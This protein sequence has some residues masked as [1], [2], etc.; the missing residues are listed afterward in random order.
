MERAWG[1]AFHC[2]N[3]SVTAAC[4]C[5]VDI[6]YPVCDPSQCQCLD[7]PAARRLRNGFFPLPIKRSS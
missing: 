3:A 5:S 6:P 4:R 7:D 2:W 1:L